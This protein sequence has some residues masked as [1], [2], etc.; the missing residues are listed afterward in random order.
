MPDG[1]KAGVM[2]VDREAVIAE[3]KKANLP[4]YNSLLLFSCHI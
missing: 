3:R 1:G 2:T 4:P